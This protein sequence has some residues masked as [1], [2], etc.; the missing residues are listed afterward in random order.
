MIS[1]NQKGDQ[2]RLSLILWLKTKIIKEAMGHQRI[3]AWQAKMWVLLRKNLML[4]NL[5]LSMMRYRRI[6][7]WSNL[8]KLHNVPW[9]GFKNIEVCL[10]PS[11]KAILKR[12]WPHF[13]RSTCLIWR[14]E[15]SRKRINLFNL[16]SKHPFGN[17][18]LKKSRGNFFLN[19]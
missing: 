4:I 1:I 9:A 8:S 16:N 13:S 14:R 5:W 10:L 11:R 7:F 3:I 18:L 17:N 2:T 6:V 12:E 15:D 19:N